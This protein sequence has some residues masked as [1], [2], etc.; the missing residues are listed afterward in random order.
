MMCKEDFGEQRRRV[1]IVY[2]RFA[3]HLAEIVIVMNEYIFKQDLFFPFPLLSYIV[4][5][6]I[7]SR[8]VAQYLSI[9]ER[10]LY[11]LVPKKKYF[12]INY[13]DYC[14]M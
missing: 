5:P 14:H 1:I 6:P 10:S 11:N 13:N 2:M 3:H 4:P 9:Q 12:I 8:N 7:R